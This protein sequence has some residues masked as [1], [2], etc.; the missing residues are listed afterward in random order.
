MIKKRVTKRI[1]RGVIVLC[2]LTLISACSTQ[3]K[4]VVPPGTELSIYKRPPVQVPA[5]GVVKTSPFFWTASGWPPGGGAPYALYKDG[6]KIKEGK[7]RVKFRVVSVFWP[8]WAVIYW[9]MG[10]NPDITYDLV[11][12]KQE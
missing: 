6:K 4:F 3:G 11:R 12:D 10:L 7:L 5:D 1:F 9:P 8:P 2:L